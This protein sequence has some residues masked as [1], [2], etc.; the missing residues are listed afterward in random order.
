MVSWK[1]EEVMIINSI[2]ITSIITTANSSS[3]NTAL[4]SHSNYLRGKKMITSLVLPLLPL[5]SLPLFHLL[6]LLHPLLISPTRVVPFQASKS[7]R[8]LLKNHPLNVLQP[9]IDIPRS[10]DVAVGSECQLFVQPGFFNSL[11]N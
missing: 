1:E 8:N 6:P 4:L 7:R 9:K 3:S 2:T 11:V 5:L 10:T